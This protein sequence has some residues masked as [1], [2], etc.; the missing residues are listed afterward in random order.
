WCQIK[1]DVMNREVVTMKNTQDAACLGAAI[2]AGYGYGAWESMEEAA[3][4]FSE[5]DRVYKPNP[6]NRQVYDL[7]L[8]KWDVLINA[9][10]GSTEEL[11]RLL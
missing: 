3:L 9:L 11:A 2:M 5:I 1:A 6:A 7:L 10:A 8:N 4:R